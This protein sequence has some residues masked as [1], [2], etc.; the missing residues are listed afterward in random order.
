[1]IK[2]EIH[3]TRYMNEDTLAAYLDSLV[4]G[5]H[6]PKII[7]EVRRLGRGCW[8]IGGATTTYT[9]TRVPDHCPLCGA[10]GHGDKECAEI[11]F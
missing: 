1:M 11:P 6:P 5:G 3:S 4:A 9:V 10:P 7:S 2:V 8:S